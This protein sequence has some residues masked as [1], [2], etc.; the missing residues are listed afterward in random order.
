MKH[1][2]ITISTFF[3]PNA[4]SMGLVAALALTMSLSNAG[5]L[6]DK[7]PTEEASNFTLMS[8]HGSDI[9]LSDYEGKFVL[10]NF[11]AT[12]CPPC[13]K[14]MPALNQLHN[15]LNASNGLEVVGVHVGPAL[16]TVKQFLKDKPVDFDIVIDKNMSLSSWQVSGLP[17]T[18]LISPS[19]K[20]IYKATGEREWGSD[21]MVEFVRGIMKEY[22][23]LATA[24]AKATKG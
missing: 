10:L 3:K 17:T 1:S 15:K 18:F 7:I 5:G 2:F 19:G 4:L 23:R 20:L 22:E 11:W 12:W 8:A 13:V 9:S 6:M 14:E 24:D 21:E 16:A